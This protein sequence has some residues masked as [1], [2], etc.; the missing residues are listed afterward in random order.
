MIGNGSRVQIIDGDYAGQYGYV[1]RVGIMTT[2]VGAV[3]T[4]DVTLD[5]DG[6]TVKILGGQAKAI[7]GTPVRW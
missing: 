7:L 4:I 3:A 6:E 1:L 5:R 2:D